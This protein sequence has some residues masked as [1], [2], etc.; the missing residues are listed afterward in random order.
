MRGGRLEVWIRDS[1]KQPRHHLRCPAVS[2]RR[3][4]KII[5][6][7]GFLTDIR[8]GFV[9]KVGHKFIADSEKEYSPRRSLGWDVTASKREFSKGSTSVAASQSLYRLSLS[10]LSLLR[11]VGWLLPSKLQH[12]RGPSHRR[13]RWFLASGLLSQFRLEIFRYGNGLTS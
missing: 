1:I 4:S 7:S 6:S 8:H 12:L 2:L 11:A 13:H 10:I 9:D 5:A 3:V